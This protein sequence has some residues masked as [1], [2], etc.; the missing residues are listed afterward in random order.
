M[1]KYWVPFTGSLNIIFVS[2]L[3][4]FDH[5]ITLSKH[6]PNQA[7]HVKVTK[8]VPL[9]IQLADSGQKWQKQKQL[10]EAGC[11]QAAAST[12]ASTERLK[13]SWRVAGAAVLLVLSQHVLV[14]LVLLVVAAVVHQR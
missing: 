5:L 13:L 12:S 2:P 7:L 4:T 6:G 9:Q 11:V 1:T 14:L 8:E 3:I 10:P